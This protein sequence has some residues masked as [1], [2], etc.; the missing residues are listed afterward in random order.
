VLMGGFY[1]VLTHAMQ[2]PSGLNAYTVVPFF[3]LG[4]AL[5]AIPM[6]AWFMRR[7]VSGTPVAFSNYTSARG[8]WHVWGM[9]GGFLWDCGLQTNLIASSAH[10]VGPAVSYA[11]GQGATMIS[12]V[13][14]V[15]VWHEFRNAPKGTGRLLAVM[16]F[17]FLLGLGLIALA[18]TIH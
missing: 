15:F 17:F 7:P 12:A 6:N 5:C 1:P 10:L 11:I 3:A 14:G 9:I 8:S 4:V 2:G 16:F 13:W 18:P